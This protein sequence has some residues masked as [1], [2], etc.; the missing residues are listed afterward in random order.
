MKPFITLLNTSPNYKNLSYLFIAGFIIRALVFGLYVQYNER[1]KQAD[2]ND[3]HICAFLLS[4]NQT[5]TKPNGEPIFWRTPGYPLFL[6]PFYSVVDYKNAE[7]SSYAWAQKASIWVQIFLC[8]FIPIIILFLAL[9]LT[10][11]LPIAWICSYI[12]VFHLGFILAS[13]YLLTDALASLLF[14]LFLWMFY[15]SWN[16]LGESKK[17]RYW[18]YSLSCAAFMLA[19]YTWMRP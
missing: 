4:Y 15:R 1:Y 12:S 18:F 19:A 11:I 17:I 3:Y 9:L 5:M 8:S 16:L 13:T 2:S 10:G 6:M 14:F 7:F